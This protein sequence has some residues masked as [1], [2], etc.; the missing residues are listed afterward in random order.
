MT[1]Y[2]VFYTDMLGKR[3][4]MSEKDGLVDIQFLPNFVLMN[5]KQEGM[6]TTMYIPA[7]DVHQIVAVHD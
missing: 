4:T 3:V 1:K 2:A 5:L 6:R 7:K